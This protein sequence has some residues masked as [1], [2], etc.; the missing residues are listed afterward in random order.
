[1]EKLRV[2]VLGDGLLGTEIV[3]QT[4]W[5][6]ISRRKDSFDIKDFSKF[7]DTMSQ[8]DVIVNCIANTNTYSNDKKDHWETN[9]KFV[10]TLIDFCNNINIKLV[11]ISTDYVYTGSV[12]NATE[13]DVPVHCSN[14]YGYTKLLSD[15]LVQLRCDDYLL[16]R[17]SHKP[18]PFPYNKAWIDLVGNFDYVDI[19]ASKIIQLVENRNFG[20][21]NVGTKSKTIYDLAKSTNEEVEPVNS[22]IYTPKNI[23]MCTEKMNFELKR[24]FFSIAIPA[25]GYN[26]KGVDFLNHSFKILTDQTIKDF[27]VIISDHSQDDTLKD[28]CDRWSNLLDIKYFKNELGRGF[29]SPNLNNSLKNSNGK[30]IK[31][32]FQDDYLY[33][34]ESLQ[35]LKNFIDQES[36]SIWIASSFWHTNDGKNLYRRLKPR[37]PT[38]PIWEGHNSIGCP[39]VIAIKNDN[40]IY[41]DD[42]LNWLMDC[43]YYQRMFSIYGHPKILDLDMVVNRNVED[44]LTNTISHEQRAYE[45]NKLKLLYDK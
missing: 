34:N 45:Y 17:C 25:Y 14:W 29:I 37:W 1:M 43:E 22:P 2:L 9:Y 24:P 10:D 27:A 23:S 13:E 4:G 39:S 20:L 31:I 44:R 16:V 40:I 6:Y 18:N 5:N 32:L 8:Y 38:Q 21:F 36:E 30:W 3:K 35:E 7:H 42:D 19:I 33:N 12:E 15:G 41:F 26:G 11:H 28:L